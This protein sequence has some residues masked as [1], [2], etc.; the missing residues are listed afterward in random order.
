MS[1]SKISASGKPVSVTP[2]DYGASKGNS[3]LREIE[4]GVVTGFIDISIGSSDVPSCGWYKIGYV[5]KLPK[6]TVS[7]PMIESWHGSI[8]GI[9]QIN[10]AGNIFVFPKETLSRNASGVLAIVTF[11]V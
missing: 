8:T 10:T 6:Q 11:L 9:V 4:G 7:V 1:V 2:S 3:F 5:G